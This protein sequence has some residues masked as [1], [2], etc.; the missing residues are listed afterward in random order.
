MNGPESGLSLRAVVVN[1]ARIPGKS[2]PEAAV[3]YANAGWPVFPLS[4]RGKLP[5]T[6]NGFRDAS[7]D[8]AIVRNRWGRWPTVN[9]GFVPGRVGLLVVDIDG[10]E[11]E[12]SASRLGLFAEPTLEVQTGR[13][14]HLLIS[15][16]QVRALSR[17]CYGST[18]YA[19]PRS[20]VCR[21]R[22][23]GGRWPG[24]GGGRSL[25]PVGPVG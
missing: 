25:G 22:R 8:P 20:G 14:R 12:A 24:G 4:L 5:L 2:L 7:S 9:I 18:T 6:K 11:G 3:A 15:G 17:E 23:L 19:I 10:A 13:G 1:C 16:S 21:F